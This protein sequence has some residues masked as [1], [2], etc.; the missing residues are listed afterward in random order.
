MG[1]NGPMQEIYDF[2]ENLNEIVYVADMDTY[3]LVYLNRKGLDVYGFRSLDEI[4]GR[5]CYD[6]LQHACMPCNI[7]TNDEL[8]PGCFKEWPY[9]NPAIDRYFLLKDT[10][11]PVDGKRY[12]LEISIDI[13]LQEKQRNMFDSYQRVEEIVNA[14][15]RLA[16]MA[17]T[18]NRGLNILLEYLGKALQAD[19]TYIFERNDKGNDDNTYEWVAAGV[20]PEKDNL[21][22]VPAEVCAHWYNTFSMD[23]IVVIR[24]LEDIRKEDP[25]QYEN[26]KRQNIDSLVVIPLYENGAAIGFCGVDN[27]PAH[28]LLHSADILQI[29][30]HFMVSLLRTRDLIVQLKEMS[31]HDRLTGFGNRYALD[32]YA[33]TLGDGGSLGVVFCD[34]TG[35]KGLND[36]RGH[37]AG[38]MLILRACDCLKKAF[39]GSMLFRI[40]GDEFLILCR[41]MAEEE[42]AS[43]IDNL[44]AKLRESDVVMA[45]GSAWYPI[46]RTSNMDKLTIE[47]EMRMYKDKAA[48]YKAAGIDRR[49]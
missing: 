5:K 48:Y 22:D 19:R 24:Q 20:S 1:G 13:T 37:T 10:M 6:V 40:G 26:L 8:R 39:G 29:M 15:L 45:L 21:Q 44:K 35:L 28:L 11:L 7:C 12:R 36:S 25:L 38:D 2:F 23:K 9:Y 17:K 32:D 41:D 3:E 27:P 30:G 14:G 49:K 33:A 16:M 18:P 47:A 31:S 43:R 46:C 4:R 34:I 42:L